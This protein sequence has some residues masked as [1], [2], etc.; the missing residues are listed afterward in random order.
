M[1]KMNNSFSE[2]CSFNLIFLSENCLQEDLGN[3]KPWKLTLN[4]ENALF[5]M[6]RLHL[7]EQDKQVAFEYINF[8]SKRLLILD[9]PVW[10]ST[11]ELTMLII[12]SLL[13]KF[14]SSNPDH[15]SYASSGKSSYSTPFQ[16]SGR[17]TPKCIIQTSL[18][19]ISCLVH[20]IV[21]SNCTFSNSHQT[22]KEFL[23]LPNHKC[24]YE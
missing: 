24:R 7:L 8:H 4:S 21:F 9:T 13:S 19:N 23:H 1:T 18:L 22:E 10:F 6:A 5:L 16:S 20:E 12:C 2:S 14:E 11:T 15:Y 17:S 3:K